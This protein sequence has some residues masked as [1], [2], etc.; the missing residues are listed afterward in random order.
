MNELLL[1]C[2]LGGRRAAIPASQVQSVIEIDGVT[3]IPRAPDRV[4]GLTALRS[5]ALTVIDCRVVLGLEP[6]EIRK[7]SRAAVV[8]HEG[9]AYA[10]L[11][12]EAYDVEEAVSDIANL[13]GG[14]GEGWQNAALGMVETAQGPALVLSVEKLVDGPSSDE[15]DRAA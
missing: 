13:P 8:R 9:H 1:M 6:S 5:Q 15:I 2:R 3:P 7:D 4:V 10:L 12:D 14:F 11:V